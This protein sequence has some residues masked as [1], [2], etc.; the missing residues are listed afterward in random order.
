MA[1]TPNM[2]NFELADVKESPKTRTSQQNRAIHKYCD[3]LAEAFNKAGITHRLVLP[4]GYEI[5]TDWSMKSIKTDIWH[6]IQKELFD[7]ESTK[8]LETNQVNGVYE[9]IDRDVAG[10][11]G[12]HV[13]FPDWRALAK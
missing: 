4:N 8:D 13:S 2:G 12:I 3:L 7:T 9:I 1:N 11:Q 10:V 5:E 6:P